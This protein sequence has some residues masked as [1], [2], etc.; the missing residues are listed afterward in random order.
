L[1]AKIGSDGA[2]RILAHDTARRAVDARVLEVAAQSVAAQPLATYANFARCASCARAS[3]KSR[4]GKLLQTSRRAVSRSEKDKRSS[5]YAWRRSRRRVGCVR[6]AGWLIIVPRR[7]FPH[8]D[9]G[10]LSLCVK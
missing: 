8:R 3:N 10:S 7:V 1:S 4:V 6:D 9:S 5:S 2:S